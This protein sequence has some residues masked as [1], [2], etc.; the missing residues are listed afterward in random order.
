[1]TAIQS[2]GGKSQTPLH[3]A[4]VGLV[5]LL[6]LFT[7]F[8]FVKEMWLVGVATLLAAIVLSFLRF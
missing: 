8:L 7:A 5:C 6:L 3:F 2:R 4:Q 1:M